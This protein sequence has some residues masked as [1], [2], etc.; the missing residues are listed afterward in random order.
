[1]DIDF[2]KILFSVLCFQFL[3]VSLF[4]FQNKKGKPISN[5]LLAL[6]FLMLSL[7]VIN[8]YILV[9]DVQVSIPQILFL[10]DT[11]MLAYGPVLYIFTQSVI[12][13][14]YNFKRK[15]LIHFLPF[16]ISFILFILLLWFYQTGIFDQAT[17]QIRNQSI[18][19]Y[20]RIAELTILLHIFYNHNTL[21]TLILDMI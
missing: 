15:D 5:K 10:D 19:V 7:A 21:T 8:F 14:N 9:F 20:F 1:M 12:Y 18:P 2:L 6:V 4:L 13:K 3:F 11:F 16:F 17:K